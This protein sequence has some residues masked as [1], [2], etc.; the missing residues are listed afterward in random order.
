[1]EQAFRKAYVYVRNASAPALNHKG[2]EETAPPLPTLVD[3][4]SKL[5][6]ELLKQFPKLK[7]NEAETIC[8]KAYQLHEAA[9]DVGLACKHGLMEVT[10]AKHRLAEECPGVPPDLY[11]RALADET[12]WHG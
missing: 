2:P 7:D 5:K 8:I 11:G 12:L 10:E 3:V 4:M 9:H 6:P 1:M